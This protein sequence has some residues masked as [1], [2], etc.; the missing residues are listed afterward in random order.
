MFSDNGFRLM[1]EKCYKPALATFGQIL[2]DNM[3]LLAFDLVSNDKNN[4]M[5]NVSKGSMT[6][7]TI[8]LMELK[9]KTLK[10]C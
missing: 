4:A 10:T 8:D 5:M 9:S 7:N 3:V 2:K 6:P 1:R